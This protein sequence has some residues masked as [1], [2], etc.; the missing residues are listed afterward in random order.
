MDT[1]EIGLKILAADQTLQRQLE[2]LA[3]EGWQPVANLTPAISYVMMRTVAP[4][5][6]PEVA[7]LG[8]LTIDETKVHIYRNGQLVGDGNG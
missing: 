2:A 1:V 8:K 5:R 7:A 6:Q 3:K 4:V